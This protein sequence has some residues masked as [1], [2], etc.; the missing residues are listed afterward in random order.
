[1]KPI[2]SILTIFFLSQFLFSQACNDSC[3]IDIPKTINRQSTK[4][5]GTIFNI[6]S[7]CP[8]QSYEI[9]IKNRWGQTLF[10]SKD[11]SKKFDCK[12]IKGLEDSFYCLIEGVYCNGKKYKIEKSFYVF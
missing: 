3:T 2:L 8:V 10:T 9:T 11:P 1:M 5:N 12:S 7:D 6:L 4:E